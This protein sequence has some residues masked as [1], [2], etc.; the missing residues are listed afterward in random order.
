MPCI[1]SCATAAAAVIAG[2]RC[3]WLLLAMNIRRVQS[4]LLFDP[5]L[6]EVLLL[7]LAAALQH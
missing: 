7:F 3:S 1:L 2:C 4:W 5:V 6:F